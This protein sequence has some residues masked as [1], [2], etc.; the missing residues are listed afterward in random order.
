M[1]KKEKIL[2]LR[3]EGKTYPEIVKIVGCS[4]SLVSYYCGNNQRAKTWTRTQRHRKKN[5][6]ARKI[7]NF[8]QA[9]RRGR[10]FVAKST[11]QKLFYSGV[12]RFQCKGG[13]KHNPKSEMTFT[14]DDVLKKIGPD[15]TCYLTGRK[16]DIQE[17]TTYSF[18]HYVPR[19]KGGA[20]TL[21]NL[22]I[23]CRE[24]NIAKQDLFV[25]DLLDLCEEILV[26]HGYVVEKPKGC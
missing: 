19:S 24:A 13:G 17:A 18:D 10:S 6:L 8:K 12:R 14:K 7:D 23:S 11:P 15:P 20:N 9:K 5:P 25:P 3:A 26:H 22:R 2:K 16:I 1:E 4:K 21:E